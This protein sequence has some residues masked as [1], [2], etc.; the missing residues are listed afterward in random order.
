MGYEELPNPCQPPPRVVLRDWPGH[1]G[2]AT[3]IHVLGAH[4]YQNQHVLRDALAPIQS[5]VVIDLSWCSFLDTSVIGAILAKHTRLAADGR[6]LD[7]LIP[8]RHT[9]LWRT[10]ERLGLRRLFRVHAPLPPVP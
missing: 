2:S 4:D 9:A 7:L 5:H 6:T 3:S 8:T 1:R 10:I